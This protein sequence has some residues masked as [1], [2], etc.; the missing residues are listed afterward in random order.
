MTKS[1][2]VESYISSL[3]DLLDLYQRQEADENAI[4]EY[5]QEIRGVFIRELPEIDDAIWLR[6]GTAE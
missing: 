5:I 4:F 3:D 1:E 2:F 6:N